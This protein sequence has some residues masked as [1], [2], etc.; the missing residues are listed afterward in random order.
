[1]A[2]GDL[3][4][5]FGADLLMGEDTPRPPSNARKSADAAS[6]FE[7]KAEPKRRVTAAEARKQT[8]RCPSCTTVVPA[9]MSLCSRCGLDL[10]TGKR[11]VVEHIFEEEAAPVVAH[12]GPPIAITI[13]GGLTLMASVILG[14]IA[15][16]SLGISFSTPEGLGGLCFAAICV[17]GIYASFEFLRGKTAKLLMI[18][19]ALGAAMDI[20]M[21]IGMPVYQSIFDVNVEQVSASDAKKGAESDEVDVRIEQPEKRLERSGGFTKIKWGIGILLVNAAVFVYL[22][23]AGVRRHFEKPRF[24]APLPIP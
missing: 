3:A 4:E 18:A 5:T 21:L 19:L 23:T 9:G 10:D 12:T 7:E 16:R 22:S 15:V 11:D 17:F 6:L 24:A 1:V 20:I 13:I 8:R 14:I 2:A